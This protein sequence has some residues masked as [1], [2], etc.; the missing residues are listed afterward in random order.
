MSKTLASVKNKYFCMKCLDRNY[1]IECA[2][3][4]GRTLTK[5]NKYGRIRKFI[6][7]HNSKFRDFTK[8]PKFDKHWNWKGGRYQDKKGYWILY[9]P[10]YFSS[11]KRGR[12]REHVYFYQ[13]YHKVCVLKWA[14]VHH[15]DEN[16]DNNMPWNLIT[17]MRGEHSTLHNKGN[18][19]SEKDKSDRFCKYCNDKTHIDKKGHEG[20][21]GNKEDGFFCTKCRGYI[22][23]HGK[24]PSY[25]K[26]RLSSKKILI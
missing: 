20:W 16:K 11:T 26:K 1:I 19:Y 9:L 24:P 10:D 18:K 22:R 3:A 7:N 13:E 21:Y 12:V 6:K 25:P 2:C 23:R 14:V 5:Y 15:I 4:C 17:M 8:I